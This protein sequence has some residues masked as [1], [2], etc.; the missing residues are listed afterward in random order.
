MA[1]RYPLS[2]EELALGAQRRARRAAAQELI[3]LLDFDAAM[4]RRAMD[5]ATD[6]IRRQLR[7]ESFAERILPSEDIGAD[8]DPAVWTDGPIKIYDREVPS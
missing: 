8:F 4:Q 3:D 1:D 5:E 6:Y 2:A 7:E